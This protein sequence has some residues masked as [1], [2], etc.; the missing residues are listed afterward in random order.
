M[1]VDGTRYQ[2]TGAPVDSWRRLAIKTHEGMQLWSSHLR[3]KDGGIQ[4]VGI[5]NRRYFSPIPGSRARQTS[6]P[7]TRLQLSDAREARSYRAFHSH[8]RKL[9]RDPA[10]PLLVE[11]KRSS[12]SMRRSAPYPK[13]T[14]LNGCPTSPT[15]EE[16]RQATKAQGYGAIVRSS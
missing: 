14:T 2:I 15:N 3:C 6:S 12:T 1:A 4:N 5:E 11:C 10:S 7:C 8:V 13:S 9:T 16:D